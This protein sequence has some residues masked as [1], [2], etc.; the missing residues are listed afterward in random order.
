MVEAAKPVAFLKALTLEAQAAL[1]GQQAAIDRLPFR[2]GRE[3]R[4]PNEG[5]KKA[6]QDRRM[7]KSAP[8]NDV[9]I[10]EQTREVY[11][12]REHFLID[13]EG[14]SFRLVDRNSALGTWVEGQLVGGKRAG[15]SVQLKSGD[16]I[17][18]GSH[19]SGFIFKFIAAD[20]SA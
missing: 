14:G 1:H 16:V 15:G 6:D 4:S 12:S 7:G 18:L 2:V 10:W 13:Q 17:I 8:N 5:W 20:G 3:S 11:V 19:L 9:Y